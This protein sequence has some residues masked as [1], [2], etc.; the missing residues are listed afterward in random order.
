MFSALLFCAFLAVSIGAVLL[1]TQPRR[2][3]E[4]LA[5]RLQ[6]LYR[7]EDQQSS[8]LVTMAENA[9][10]AA[11]VLQKALRHDVFNGLRTLLVQSQSNLTLPAFLARSLVPGA[12]LAVPALLLAPAPLAATL[13]VFAVGATLPW[14]W[15]RLRRDKRLRN[16]EEALPGAAELMS[17]ALRAGHSV[18][19]ALELV[20]T[21]TTGPLADEFRQ[22]HQEQ[23]F[24]VPLREALRA[25][26]ARVPSRDLQF[27]VTAIVVQKETGGDLIDILDRTTHVIRDRLRVQR[28]VK[29]YTAQGR[30]TGWIL[31]ALPV[32]LLALTAIITPTYSAVMFHDPTGQLLLAAA[33]ALI[34]TGS[35][36][37]RKVVQVE[38]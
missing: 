11:N 27:L 30:L 10:G 31:S 2:E 9:V 7:L 22:L 18:Q 6:D 15:L 36:I 4:T 12:V 25:L 37:I 5:T 17:R 23:K 14:L 29:T 26:A 20:G 13:A 21:E 35:L 38:V 28:E 24:G 32:V 16:F 19:Q 3:D 33:A 1:C 8:S 34:I